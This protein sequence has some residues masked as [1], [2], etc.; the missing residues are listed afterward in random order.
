MRAER[1]QPAA[2]LLVWIALAVLAVAGLLFL[3]YYSSSREP[4]FARQLA[5]SVDAML[6]DAIPG[7]VRVL[8]MGSSLL[9]A[10]APAAWTLNSDPSAPMRW[11]RITKGGLGLSPLGSAF[12]LVERTPPDILVIEKNLLMQVV[13]ADP[14]YAMRLVA[15]Y[16]LLQLLSLADARFDPAR[17]IRADQLSNAACLNQ[18]Q[19]SA[20]ELLIGEQQMRLAYQH[21]PDPVLAAALLRLAGRGVH[22]MIVDIQRARAIEASTAQDKQRW[23]ARLRQLLPPGPQLSYHTG[24]SFAQPE[25]YCDARH[26]NGRGAQLFQAWWW[27]ELRET[28]KALRRP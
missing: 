27:T 21:G 7:E 1:E 5:D 25:L 9:R 15:A 3:R 8:G 12:A 4:D 2:P 24:P 10:A 23:S 22:V 17:K 11:R 26:L 20:A 16:R 13:D 6:A 14:M 28:G 19:A 18:P